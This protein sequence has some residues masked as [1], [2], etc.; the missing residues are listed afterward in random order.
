MYLNRL[1]IV[2]EGKCEVMVYI[3]VGKSNDN[4]AIVENKETGEIKKVDLPKFKNNEVVKTSIKHYSQKEFTLLINRTYTDERGWIYG[5]SYINIEKNTSVGCGYWNDEWMY[6]EITD[7]ENKIKAKIF[8]LKDEIAKH[9]T[10]I[11]NKEKEIDAL[12]YVVALKPT[13]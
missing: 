4:K 6:E 5:E 12:M 2:N 8:E 10:E 13:E 9:K 1:K 7:L 11:K 3:F